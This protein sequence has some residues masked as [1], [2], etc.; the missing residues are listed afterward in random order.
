M[1]AQNELTQEQRDLYLFVYIL[2]TPSIGDTFNQ[3][4]SNLEMLG[5]DY[6]RRMRLLKAVKRLDPLPD[7]LF[8]TFGHKKALVVTK[9]LAAHFPEY[10]DFYSRTCLN[11]IQGKDS[12]PRGNPTINCK[13]FY[14]LSSK[15]KIID[16]EFLKQYQKSIQI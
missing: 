2:Q 11:Y 1:A 7:Q 4:W 12:F 10:L 15:E 5:K 13:D 3:A 14:E 6:E 16:N 9:H 8:S